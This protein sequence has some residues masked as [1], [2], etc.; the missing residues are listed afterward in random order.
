MKFNIIVILVSSLFITACVET[1]E[2]R[3]VWVKKTAPDTLASYTVGLAIGN[4]GYLGFGLNGTS[5]SDWWA[6]DHDNDKWAR[7]SRFPGAPRYGAMR[8]SDD[9]YAYV[10]LGYEYDSNGDTNW[11]NDIWQYNPALDQWTQLT[12]TPFPFFSGSNSS[13]ILDSKLFVFNYFDLWAFDLIT[14]QWQKK[15]T[16]PFLSFG[17]SSLHGASA[18]IAD[19]AYYFF[20]RTN[21]SPEIKYGWKYIGG[22]DAWEIVMQDKR[23]YSAPLWHATFK[24]SNELYFLGSDLRGRSI[25]ILEEDPLGKIGAELHSKNK[26]L[27]TAFAINNRGYAVGEGEFWLYIPE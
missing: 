16:P 20:T 17:F 10:G 3:N 4:K 14:K 23:N 1:I 25:K 13:F 7:K 19:E 21:T 11:F 12:S 6:Y 8:A 18:V 5:R 9:Q 27:F 2:L 15:N 24:I 22:Q 26:R